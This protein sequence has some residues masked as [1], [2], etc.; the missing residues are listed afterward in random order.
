MGSKIGN[1]V[2]RNR[3]RRR[4]KEIYR[5]NEDKLL[6][7]YDIVIVARVKAVHAKYSQLDR[8]FLFLADRLG[9]LV[10]DGTGSDAEQKEAQER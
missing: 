7:G 5:L 3:V 8:S 1:A 6:T 9:L 4:L 10:S 2:K